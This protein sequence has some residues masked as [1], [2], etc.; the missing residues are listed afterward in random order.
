VCGVIWG[1]GCGKGME[2]GSGRTLAWASTPGGITL[3]GPKDWRGSTKEARILPH[4]LHSAGTW[5]VSP[6]AQLTAQGVYV[7]ATEVGKKLCMP[8]G[9][10]RSVY[11][12]QRCVML[13]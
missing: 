8:P 4:F 3:S 6:H 12:Q 10:V 5:S 13:W 11:H 9:I 2:G 1:D 7:H